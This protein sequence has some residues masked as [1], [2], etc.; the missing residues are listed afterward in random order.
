M[1][2]PEVPRGAEDE[3]VWVTPRKSDSVI[4]R[5]PVADAAR[6][7]AGTL[8]IES[9]AVESVEVDNETTDGFDVTAVG[10]GAGAEEIAGAGVD[11]DAVEVVE[12]CLGAAAAGVA[13]GCE[14]PSKGIGKTSLAVCRTPV[15]GCESASID[16]TSFKIPPSNDMIVKDDL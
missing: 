5:T 12:V 1:G 2:G 8:E 11:T 14:S 4:D 6:L 16:P 9:E 3:K 10:S 13:V 7:L 15:V